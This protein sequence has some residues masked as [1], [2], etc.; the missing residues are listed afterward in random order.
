MSG[1]RSMA[2]PQPRALD[3]IGAVVDPADLLGLSRES[4]Q[5]LR[6]G[7]R[8]LADRRAPGHC[9]RRGVEDVAAGGEQVGAA[10]VIVG[11]PDGPRVNPGVA[12]GRRQGRRPRLRAL[13]LRGRDRVE[14]GTI[15]SAGDT[16]ATTPGRRTHRAGGETP[17]N[18]AISGL[19][20]GN[21]P[22]SQI[23]IHGLKVSISRS[24]VGAGGSADGVAVGATEEDRVDQQ[25]LQLPERDP[26]PMT[27]GERDD[28]LVGSE[29]SSR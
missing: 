13:R 7:H 2:G 23:L 24:G 18:N 26:L 21:H 19:E 29:R 1:L 5:L 11:H 17:P 20:P 15:R 6:A 10:A 3:S 16:D 28:V 27:G 4:A 8:W 14:Q 22:S 12:V 25:R 9:P